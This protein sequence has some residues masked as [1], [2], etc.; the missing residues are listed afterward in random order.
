MRENLPGTIREGNDD[1]ESIRIMNE[2][3]Y[4]FSRIE[5]SGEYFI[6]AAAVR[7]ANFDREIK[8]YLKENPE[9]SVVS[10]GSGLETTFFRVDNGKLIWYDLDLPEIIELRRKYVPPHER[11]RTVARSCFDYSWTGQIDYD[12]GKGL[13]FIVGGVFYYFEEEK[14]REFISTAAERFPGARMFFDSTSKSG[15]KISNRYVRKTGNTEAEM[16]FGLN[17]A[18]KYFAPY[19]PKVKVIADYPFYSNISFGESWEGGTKFRMKF[20]DLF[21]MVKM[22]GLEFP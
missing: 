20:S 2:S 3:G 14:V 10:I 18:R 15:L 13:I 9:A 21:R 4:D 8:V 16:Y 22:V 1:R 11:V 6:L 17:S 12:R 7:A 5:D 19:Y